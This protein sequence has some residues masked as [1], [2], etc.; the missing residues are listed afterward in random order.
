MAKIQP[1]LERISALL[2]DAAYPWKSIHVAGTNGKG[3]V[4]HYASSML[5][6]RSVNVGK[7]TSPHLVDR[8]DCITVNGKPVPET[9]FRIVEKHVL[10]VDKKLSIGASPFEILTAVAFTCFHDAKVEVGVVEVGMGGKLDSTNILNNQAVS[11]ITKIARDHQDFLGNTLSEIAAHK[12]GILR[13]DVPYIINSANEANVQSVIDDYARSIGA[14]PRLVSTSWELQKRLY[15]ASKWQ[16]LTSTLLPFQQENLKLAVVAVMHVLETLAKRPENTPNSSRPENT[17]N[18]SSPKHMKPKDKSPKPLELAKTLLL[19]AKQHH[20]GRQEFVHATPVFKE[21]SQRKNHVLVDGAH[22]PDAAE[23]LNEFVHSHLRFGQSPTSERPANGWPVTWVLAMTAGKDAHRYLATI[24]KPGD[25]VVTTTFGPVDGMPWV[26]PMDPREL[27]EAA[28]SVEPTITGVHVPV[29]GALR[30]LCTA[31]YMSNQIAPWAPI[32]LTGSLYLVGDLHREL[33]PRASKTWWTDTTTAAKA[34]REAYLA[35]QAAERERVRAA[36]KPG[37]NARGDSAAEERAKLQAELE[38][39]DFEFQGLE[40]EEMRLL[41]NQTTT[42]GLTDDGTALSAGERLELEDRRF[43]E[44]HSTPE[45]LAA[46][47]ERAEKAKAALARQNAWMESQKKAR[48]EKLE[49]RLVRR[50]RL[51]DRR[52]RKTNKRKLVKQEKERR[53]DGALGLGEEALP[54]WL[55]ARR[56]SDLQF[57]TQRRIAIGD[58]DRPSSSSTPSTLPDTMASK[59]TSQDTEP[60]KMTS[61]PT[62]RVNE[63]GDAISFHI[64]GNKVLSFPRARARARAGLTTRAMGSNLANRDTS[65]KAELTTIIPARQP[66]PQDALSSLSTPDAATS[67]Q[68]ERRRRQS[69]RLPHPGPRAEGPNIVMHYAHVSNLR[70]RGQGPPREEDR[71]QT[72]PL[73]TGTQEGHRTPVKYYRHDLPDER[74][75][76]GR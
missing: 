1:G 29:L 67:S 61:K 6:G 62:S 56:Q 28:K 19:N 73:A 70:T 44:R 58:P 59:P 12:A 69:A 25:K 53:R 50:Q 74:E 2:K 39:L 18:S 46:Y 42:L 38:A 51:E 17:P 37:A 48:E 22:N 55:H 76:E 36:L 43:A 30:A 72:W 57:G 64:E 32:A 14:G 15:D 13:P 21:A 23:T 31:K 9:K 49:K 35:I 8:W 3:S 10:G 47:L 27:L 71:V 7:F 54:N 33:R 41:K 65:S 45:Q 63:P 66:E 20:A 68:A 40:I 60:D 26:K 75:G 4:C 52:E 11:V 5:V 16:R 34:D 24:L